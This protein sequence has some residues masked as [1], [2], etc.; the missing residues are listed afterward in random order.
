MCCFYTLLSCF[1]RNLINTLLYFRLVFFI[2]NFAETILY[3]R[4]FIYTT[5]SN[6]IANDFANP[7]TCKWTIDHD[8]I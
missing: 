7:F 6:T 1:L 4:C 3:K 8:I 2:I 5:A